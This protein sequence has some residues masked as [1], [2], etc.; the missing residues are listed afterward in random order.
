MNLPFNIGQASE[1]AGVSAKM[2][3]YYE[4]IGLLPEVART[5]SGYRVYGE[6]DI[7]TLRFIRRARDL[8][9]SIEEIGDLLALWKDRSRRSGDV[10]RLV[11][12][13]IAD[14]RTRIAE[15][16]A[17]ADTLQH[18]ADCCAGNHRPECPILEDLETPGTGGHRIH[19]S[20]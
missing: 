5:E 19:S 7:H 1:R 6:N 4:E 8:G 15:L 16:S 9:F 12:K 10:K 11:S 2:I 13:H 14:L 17:M 18:L 20:P 3:R